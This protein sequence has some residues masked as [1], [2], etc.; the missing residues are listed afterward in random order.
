MKVTIRQAKPN[1]AK[2]LTELAMKSKAYWGYSLEFMQNCCDEL[3]ISEEKILDPLFH[4]FIA[5]FNNE[6][7]GFY[8]IEI[9]N[10]FKVELE[11]LFVY[12][13]YIG[14]GIGKSLINHAKNLTKG[15][16]AKTMLIQG[17]PNAVGFYQSIGAKK[18]GQKESGSIPGRFLPIFE[19]SV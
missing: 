10:G 6:I 18:I 5:E 19:I 7:L 4:Y 17:E 13:E 11:A 15:L 1:E 2:F 12:P 9:I 14:K 16:G 3:T 8:A